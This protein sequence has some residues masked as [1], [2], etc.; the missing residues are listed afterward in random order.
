MTILSTEQKIEKLV[1]EINELILDP[2]G[3]KKVSSLSRELYDLQML[4]NRESGMLDH[5]IYR[6]EYLD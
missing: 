1:R 5:E 4:L 2:I 3:Y 6:M